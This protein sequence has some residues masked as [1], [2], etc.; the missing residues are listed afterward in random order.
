MDAKKDFIGVGKFERVGS[1]EWVLEMWCERCK[2]IMAWE[3][4]AKR[5]TRPGR[6]NETYQCQ[7]G[8]RAYIK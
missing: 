2:T 8:E 7:C 4:L 1:G 6:V 3:L 5:P